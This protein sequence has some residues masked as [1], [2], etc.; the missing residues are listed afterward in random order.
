ML[1]DHLA[2]HP[3]SYPSWYYPKLDRS[4]QEE[5]ILNAMKIADTEDLS[6]S[7]SSSDYGY[8]PISTQ[9]YINFR[10]ISQDNM[11]YLEG[12]GGYEYN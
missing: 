4:G 2:T 9:F 10:G 8:E 1:E 11:D 3:F 12:L 6:A 7:V 5:I